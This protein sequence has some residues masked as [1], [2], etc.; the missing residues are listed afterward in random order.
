MNLFKSIL[1]LSLIAFIPFGLMIWVRTHQTTGFAG[2]ELI[3]YP[4]IFGGLGIAI[5][6]VTKKYFLNEPLSDFNTTNGS[7]LTDIYWGI[8]LTAIYF[9]LFFIERRTLSHILQM[10]ANQELLDLILEMRGDPF[11]LFMFFGPVLWIG[12]ALYE[13][14]IR[15]FMLTSMWKWSENQ[16]WIIV[17]IV[18]SAS[19]MGLVH[20]HQGSYGIV[21]ISIKGL[22]SGYYFLRKRRLLPLIIA[23]ALYDGLQVAM[24]LLTYPEH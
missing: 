18:I 19:V 24:F 22:V 1:A 20:W 6:Y 2:I 12:V 10:N 5:V 15:V 9:A 16:F 7:L 21:T 23:H 3:A 13:E 11:I 8:I 14:L 4:L 17:V